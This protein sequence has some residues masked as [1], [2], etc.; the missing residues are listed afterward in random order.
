MLQP[1]PCKESGS[2]DPAVHLRDRL[3]AMARV[4]AGYSFERP[5]V[6][7][8]RPPQFPQ[9]LLRSSET[10]RSHVISWAGRHE[11][12]YTAYELH[13]RAAKVQSLWDN[14]VAAQQPPLSLQDPASR[15]DN[16]DALCA[17]AKS[18]AKQYGLRG[19]PIWA[20][21]SYFR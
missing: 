10:P 21:L 7:W 6:N 20:Q 5:P 19:L 8:S 9:H 13:Q 2:R 12:V 18:T 15:R 14:A 3:A 11:V 1:V 4:P 16:W 17:D